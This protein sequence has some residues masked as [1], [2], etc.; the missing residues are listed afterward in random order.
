MN[1]QKEQD[2]WDQILIQEVGSGAELISVSVSSSDC[3]VYSNRNSI[4]KV[5]RLTPASIRGRLNSLEDEFLIINRLTSLSNVAKPLGYKRLGEWEILELAKIPSLPIHDPTFGQPRESLRDFLSVVRFAWSINKLGCSHGDYHFNNIGTNTEGS[6]S[7]FDFDQATLGNPVHCWLRDFIGIGAHARFTDISLVQRARKVQIIW[8]L[9]AIL[10]LA[11]G[12]TVKIIRLLQNKN[13]ASKL[14]QLTLNARAKLSNDQSLIKLAEAWDIASKSNASSPGMVL[15]YYSLDVSGINFPGERPWMLR[16]N[17]IQ[18]SIDFKGKKFL[19]LGCN[20]GLL[21]IHAKLNGALV[22]LGIDIDTDITKAASLASKAFETDVSFQQLNLDNP[23]HWEE[24]MS[25]FD[26]V[27]ALSVMHW[28]KNK[29]RVWTFLG[30]HKE[31]IYEGHESDIDSKE[32]LRKIGFTKVHSIGQSERGRQ[33]F[34]ATKE[35]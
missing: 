31:I 23:R 13:E 2:E 22:C 10:S 17:T 21:S 7:V 33:V 28:V 32:N 5:K 19:E 25:G 27:S 34:Y 3:R 4:F 24:E 12:L 9:F 18:R 15:A 8:P 29:N 30:K 26:I 20:L 35:A 11:R 16:W 1:Y 14:P 6:L